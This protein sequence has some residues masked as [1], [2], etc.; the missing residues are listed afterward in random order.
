MAEYRE[1]Q[2]RILI[3]ADAAGK[4]ELERLTGQRLSGDVLIG[5]LMGERPTGG[6]SVAVDSIRR[7]GDNVIVNATFARP[8]S[9]A[10]VIQVLTS[11]FTV[12]SVPRADLPRGT[13]RFS[14]RDVSGQEVSRAEIRNP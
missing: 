6:F 5:V 7:E 8:A 14:L 1:E 12:V 4:A 11:P 13:V 9:D 3:G 2:S 10:I